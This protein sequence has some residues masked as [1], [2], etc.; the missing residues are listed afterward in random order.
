MQTTI[1]VLVNL[2]CQSERERIYKRKIFQAF[3]RGEVKFLFGSIR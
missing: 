3:G 2:T 1:F